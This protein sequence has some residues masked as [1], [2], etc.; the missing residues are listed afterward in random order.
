[1]VTHDHLPPPPPIPRGMVSVYAFVRG[2]R[3]QR[4]LAA[5][6][7]LTHPALVHRLTLHEG[8][9]RPTALIDESN[10]HVLRAFC[11]ARLPFARARSNAT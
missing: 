9:G 4:R 11:D 7:I 8:G 5:H 2:L 10:L 6:F 1:M 3:L